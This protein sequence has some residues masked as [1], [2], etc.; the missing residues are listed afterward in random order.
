MA[1]ASLAIGFANITGYSVLSGLA[2]G[3]EPVRG[4]RPA[5]GAKNSPL[6]VVTCRSPA[7]AELAIHLPINYL[8]VSVLELRYRRRRP[9]LRLGESQPCHL[10]PRSPS[11]TSPACTVTPEA[12]WRLASSAF[13]VVVRDVWARMFM[14]DVDILAS[15]S[16]PASVL[17]ILGLC[18]LGNCP[19]RPPAAACSAASRGQRR[20]AHTA[21]SARSFY[22]RRRRARRRRAR[23]LGRHGLPRGSAMQSVSENRPNR[24]EIM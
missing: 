8:L 12:S 14:T 16:R 3:M 15:R 20:T 10:P 13:A 7:C 22:L 2:M 11:S 24:S 5:L 19:P 9:R 4:V 1:G 6:V 21:T 18:E 17:L 23:V